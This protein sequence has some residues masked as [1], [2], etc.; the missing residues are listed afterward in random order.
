LPAWI[1]RA[2]SEPRVAVNWPPAFT[3]TLESLAL[4]VAVHPEGPRAL[5][6]WDGY[7]WVT[8]GVAAN[9]DDARAVIGHTLTPAPDSD[10]ETPLAPPGLGPGPGRHRKPSP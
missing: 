7:A 8:V 3:V 10:T 5:L 4:H 2:V 1:A 9:A 6:E